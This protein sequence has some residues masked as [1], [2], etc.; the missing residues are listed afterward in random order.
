MYNDEVVSSGMMFIRRLVK[1]SHL[2]QKLLERT[3]TRA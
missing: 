2:V 3:D 1:I